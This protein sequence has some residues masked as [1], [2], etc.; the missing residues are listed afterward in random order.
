M[1]RRGRAVFCALISLLLFGAVAQAQEQKKVTVSTT[2]GG[3]AIGIISNIIETRG[4]GK[5]H[6]LAIDFKQFDPA[7]AEEAVFFKSV[8][9]GI[10]APISAARANLKGQKIQLFHPVMLSIFTFLV[11]PDS[12]ARTVDDLKGKKLGL[13]ARVTAMYTSFATIAKMRGGDV[14][15]DYK[16]AFGTPQAVSAFLI[17][18]DVDAIGM[19]EPRASLMVSANQARELVT[20]NELWQKETGQPLLIIGIA[21][22]KE[23][24]DS[25]PE[26]ARG[27]GRAYADGVRLLKEN[28][29]RIMEEQRDYIGIKTPE[30]LKRVA[31]HMP[32]L[33]IGGWTPK[34]LE[35]TNLLIQKNVEMKILEQL[36]KEEFLRRLE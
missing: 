3:G 26:A 24:L 7:K 12:P 14:E 33:F 4:L 29:T 27:L 22:Y 17:R 6:G 30:E 31:S 13:F 36:P 10:F 15:K 19:F 34:L 21:A 2:G 20:F 16:L 18:K 23:W 32:G 8:D 28:P 9:A 11:P 1:D 35:S 5:K 25:N